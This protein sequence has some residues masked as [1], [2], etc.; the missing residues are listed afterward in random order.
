MIRG[1]SNKSGL[2]RENER[3]RQER[4]AKPIKEKIDWRQVYANARLDAD[5]ARAARLNVDLTTIRR[6]HGCLS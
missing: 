5:L 3:R 1:Y 6:L 4:L 2:H